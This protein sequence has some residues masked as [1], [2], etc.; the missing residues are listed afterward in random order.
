MGRGMILLNNSEKRNWEKQK[1]EKFKKK[2]LVGEGGIIQK[3]GDIRKNG[4]KNP[5]M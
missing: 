4:G 5:N 1:M 3:G 2:P